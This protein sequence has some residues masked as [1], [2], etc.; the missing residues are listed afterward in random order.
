MHGVGSVTLDSARLLHMVDS[1][2]EVV[3]YQHISFDSHPMTE[4]SP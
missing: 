3:D 1:K 4:I 2:L